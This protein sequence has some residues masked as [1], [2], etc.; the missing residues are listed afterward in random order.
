MI[1]SS[2]VVVLE[3]SFFAR[4][5]AVSQIYRSSEGWDHP[6][7]GWLLG[8]LDPLTVGGRS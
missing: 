1:R 2:G 4:V 6:L 7:A 8:S 5:A 3:L